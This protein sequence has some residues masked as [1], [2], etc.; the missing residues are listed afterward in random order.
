M[1]T[2]VFTKPSTPSGQAP[3][4]LSGFCA[5]CPDPTEVT[6]ALGACGFALVFEMPA[7]RRYARHLKLL[8]AQYH[9]EHQTGA[10]IEYLA[11]EDSP[12]LAVGERDNEDCGPGRLPYYPPHASRFWSTP[13]TQDEVP[14]DAQDALNARWLFT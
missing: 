3:R 13:G 11:G 14:W 1:S 6:Q 10:H 5:A 4:T 12:S 9:Y 2:T 8:P 7:E